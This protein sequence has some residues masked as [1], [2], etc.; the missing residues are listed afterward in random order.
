MS[1]MCIID[2]KP[3]PCHICDVQYVPHLTYGLLSCSVLNCR[4][5]GILFENGLCKIRNKSGCLIAESLKEGSLYF[6]NTKDSPMP[7]TSV[8]ADAA[9][10]IPPSF[11]LVHK[12]LTHPGK[13]TLQQM[14]RKGLVDG[15]TSVPD[16]S[17]FFN[18]VTCICGKMTWGPFQ[19]GHVVAHECLGCLHSDVCGPMEVPSLG[20]QHYFCVLVNDKTGYLWFHPCFAKSDF[21]PWFVKM[22]TFFANH[23]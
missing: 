20:K 18:C 6:L 15:L 16:D 7:S 9:L 21:M 22:D 13:D 5:L 14:I 12:Q 19:E 4:G 23:Y 2:S 1:V 11:D 10:V 8:N 17:K 3:V